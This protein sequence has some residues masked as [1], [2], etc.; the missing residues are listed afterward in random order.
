MSR[1]PRVD[2]YIA[3]AQPF[4]RPVMEHVR[5]RVH[6]VLPQAEETLKWSAPAFTLDG[7]IVLMLAAFKA[8][9]ALN[10]W[11]GQELRGE[12]SS[13][14]GMG[15]F[16]K[17]TSVADLPPDAELERLISEAARLARSAPAP[18]KVKHAPKAEPQL[19]PDFAAALDTA[20]KAKAVLDGFSPGA[21]RE[22]L[23]WIADAKRDETRASRIATAIEWLSEG[24]KKNWKYE[25]C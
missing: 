19:H 15:Q 11:R 5:E 24:K 22:Y 25:R 23:D 13:G 1:D 7:K 16:G 8:H 2:A 20:P 14:E 21:R 12:A 18:R 6:E 3:R 17:L 4:A 9:A 10:F